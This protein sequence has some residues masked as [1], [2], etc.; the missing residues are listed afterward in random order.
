MIEKEI[1][2]EYKKAEEDIVKEVIEEAKGI[3]SKLEIDDRVYATSHRQ[4][5][6]TLKDHKPN[7]QNV[8]SC[9]LLNPTKSEIGRVSKK[10]VEKINLIVRDKSKVKNSL[11]SK[12]TKTTRKLIKTLLRISQRRIKR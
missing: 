11:K 12:S 8:Q 1:N 7:F 9:R 5:F 10:I 3:A 6:I 4:A 2:K